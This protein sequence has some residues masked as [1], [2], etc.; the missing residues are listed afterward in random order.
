MKTEDVQDLIGLVLGKKNVHPQDRLMEDLGAESVDIVS[1]M[2]AIENKWG[3][4]LKE[5]DFSQIKTVN[6]LF[7]TL[8]T[9]F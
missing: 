8:K 4:D 1:I 5:S 2:A 9:E 7:A 3:F 6:D